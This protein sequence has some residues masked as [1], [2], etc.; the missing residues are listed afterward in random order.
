MK[1]DP[2]NLTFKLNF[3]KNVLRYGLGIKIIKRSSAHI[4]KPNKLWFLI[5]Y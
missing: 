4:G 5:S 3:T 1:N 2:A